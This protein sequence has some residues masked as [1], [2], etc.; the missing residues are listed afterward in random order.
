MKREKRRN[1]KYKKEGKSSDSDPQQ[2]QA[3]GKIMFKRSSRGERIEGG[4][5]CAGGFSKGPDAS[6]QGGNK[7]IKREAEMSKDA[8]RRENGYLELA[9]GYGRILAKGA[10]GEGWLERV[11]ERGRAV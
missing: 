1:I 9:E 7:N 3:A 8:L 4:L 6:L 11:G 10:R 5:D 2:I